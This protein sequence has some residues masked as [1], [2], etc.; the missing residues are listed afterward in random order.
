[1]VNQYVVL[2]Y[3]VVR[4]HFVCYKTKPCRRLVP[5]TSSVKYNRLNVEAHLL[6]SAVLAERRRWVGLDEEQGDVTLARLDL[7]TQIASYDV[8]LYLL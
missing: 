4:D 3:A 6:H 1:M 8:Y 2:A 7:K 5:S